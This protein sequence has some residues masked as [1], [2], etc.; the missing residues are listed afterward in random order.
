MQHWRRY[1]HDHAHNVNDFLYDRKHL[2]V[3]CFI[4]AA[5]H[6]PVRMDLLGQHKLLCEHQRWANERLS[7]M[8]DQR[9]FSDERR[10]YDWRRL[11][12]FTDQHHGDRSGYGAWSQHRERRRAFAV[13]IATGTSAMGTGAITSGT[14][15]TVVTTT[16]TGATTA[17]TIVATPTADRPASQAMRLRLLG[18]FTF[19]PT[20][21]VATSTSR[22]ATTHRVR[23]P[24]RPSISQLASFLKWRSDQV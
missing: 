7:Y 18:V 3:W 10:Y 19:R 21:Q 22:C 14:C 11:A 24:P 12:S 1:P 5:H 17:S 16:A 23:S 2:H 4:H 9:S 15:A 8:R 6:G 20:Q 13:I